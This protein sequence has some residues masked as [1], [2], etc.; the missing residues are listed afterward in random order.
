MS[1]LV[2]IAEDVRTGRRSAAAVVERTLD[3][4]AATDA[5]LGAWTVVDFDG[6]IAQAR[7]VDGMVAAGTDPGL[8]AGV[9]VAVKD[10]IDVVGMV[11]GAGF[12]P[13]GRN[14]ATADA[15]V[16]TDLRRLGAVIV[17]KVT[18]AQFAVSDPPASTR[19]PWNPERTPGGS[20]TGSGVAVA[21]GHVP[22]ALGTQTGGSILR[23]AAYCG[24]VGLKPT[25]GA[26]PGDG[27]LPVAPSLD[28]VGLLAGSVVDTAHAF[29]AL[30]GADA[31]P[32][33]TPRI[34]IHRPPVDAAVSGAVD[35]AV[36]R[37]STA[38]AEVTVWEPPDPL[39]LLGSVYRV[40]MTSELAAIH[41]R[42]FPRHR[43]AYGPVIAGLIEAAAEV[44]GADLVDAQR[45]RGLAIRRFDEAFAGLDAVVLPPVVEPPPHRS[46]TGGSQLLSP[47]SVLGVPSLS[48]PVGVVDGLPA[49]MQVVGRRGGD[50]ALL[51]VAAWMERILGPGPKSR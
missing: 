27:V 17:G 14:V 7:R 41:R 50:I 34:G 12:E 37:L 29:G 6:A 9:P 26:L 15:A 39:E 48:L 40:I 25:F 42:L 32:G 46:T 2:A 36:E 13:F 38:G 33:K 44:T 49:G 31:V 24:V 10:I 4:I 19:N 21:A 43:A 47:F 11:T 28:H 45:L 30:V 23:P 18:T 8:L 51:G 5:H 16:V 1:D 20:S 3:T 22:L 35:A